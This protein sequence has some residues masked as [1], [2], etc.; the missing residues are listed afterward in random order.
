MA[1]Y[2][3]VSLDAACMQTNKIGGICKPSF[4]SLI[5]HIESLEYKV[6]FRTIIVSFHLSPVLA[7]LGVRHNCT[8]KVIVIKEYTVIYFVS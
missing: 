5:C 1:I 3:I 2:Q 7:Q 4:Y 8:Y 6:N